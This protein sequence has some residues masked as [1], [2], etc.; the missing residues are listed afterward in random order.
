M[1]NP[2]EAANTPSPSDIEQLIADHP[3]WELHYCKVGLG[4]QGFGHSIV[5]CGE[6]LQHRLW[7]ADATGRRATQVQFC[8][9][10]GFQALNATKP[11]NEVKVVPA[12]VA[13][14]PRDKPTA[15]W[16]KH[17]ERIMMSHFQFGSVRVLASNGEH[18]KVLTPMGAQMTVCV[19]NLEP[20]KGV[21]CLPKVG[22]TKEAKPKKDK[23]KEMLDKY[24]NLGI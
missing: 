22:E 17:N 3:D 19:E 9:F 8:P 11:E 12:D 13:L 10:C 18:A 7:A 6:D 24:L 1:N 14:T 2:C 16:V 23:T 15:M 21:P 20:L 4:H 5:C